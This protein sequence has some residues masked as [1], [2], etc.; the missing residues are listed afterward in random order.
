M[1][2]SG[3]FYL[4]DVP[5]R[6]LFVIGARN[7]S[8]HFFFCKIIKE[9]SDDRLRDLAIARRSFFDFFNHRFGCK[10]QSRNLF[11]NIKPLILRNTPDD[12][13]RTRL[14]V[15]TAPCAFI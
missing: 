4:H 10:R 13:L 15:Q 12:R 7:A 6:K 5:H 9:G 2:P 3:F 14:F 8:P 1:R 11:G